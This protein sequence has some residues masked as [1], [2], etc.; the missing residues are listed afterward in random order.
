MSRPDSSSGVAPRKTALLDPFGGL[1]GDMLLGALLDLDA[2][3]E[4]DLEA[5][6]A[7]PLSSLNLPDWRLDASPA[8]RRQLGCVKATFHV[9]DEADHRHLPEI[10]ARIEASSL[11]A[12]AKHKAD[13]AFVVLAEA[14]AKVHRIPVERVHFH[15][16]GAADAILDICAVSF[17]L[18]RLGV[19][20]LLCG[21]LPGGS[22]TIR[23]A[24]GD[25]PCPAPAVVHLL[26]DFVVLAGVGEGEMVTPT[27]AALLRAWGRPLED[28]ELGYRSRGVGY[29]AGTRERS[30]LRVSLVEGD[31]Q[32]LEEQLERD[33]ICVLETHLDDES[34]E[35]L[36]WVSDR[37]FELGAVDVAFAPLTMKKGRPGLALTVLVPP[38]LRERAVATILRETTALGVREQVV[39]RT[40]LAREITTLDT[41][42]GPVRIKHAGGR[43]RPEYEDLARIA[44]ARQLPL[45][46][47]A[48]A[49][50]ALAREASKR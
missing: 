29:G 23:C 11:P 14:E 50:A 25:M 20:E 40:I 43:G 33:Q 21:P 22:G 2:E 17:A 8:M 34:P 47:V 27:G 18:D 42:W 31:G 15:E 13:A 30:V 35:L 6:L 10:R 7:E 3:L 24:H 28:G 5:A 38:P 41:P 19:D 9:P 46:E 4:G 12:R 45:R 36:A 39:A 1:A 16:V 37:L 49:V 44:R 26:A 32:E 48:E